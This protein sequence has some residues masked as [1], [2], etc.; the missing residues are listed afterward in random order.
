MLKTSVFFKYEQSNGVT[1]SGLVKFRL[2]P[3]Q[4]EV[5]DMN[6]L[7]QAKVDLM[8]RKWIV[9]LVLTSKCHYFSFCYLTFADLP[10]N[11]IH[12]WSQNTAYWDSIETRRHVEKTRQGP[13]PQT[14]RVRDNT[15][16]GSYTRNTSRGNKKKEEINMHQVQL[17]SFNK[18]M[19][20]IVID[21]FIC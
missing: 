3:K 13:K 9:M 5:C 16:R 14:S 8:P 11:C 12:L 2:L 17:L 19:I 6:K 4:G 7:D 21:L 18:L 20:C 15:P 1:H 10:H